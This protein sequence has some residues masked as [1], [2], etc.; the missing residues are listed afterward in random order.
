MI[1]GIGGCSYE[2]HAPTSM[3]LHRRKVHG[4]EGS[5]STA[6][7]NRTVVA[8]PPLDAHVMVFDTPEDRELIA[9]L[10]E[11]WAL[12]PAAALAELKRR[13]LDA[14]EHDR[15]VRDVRARRRVAAPKPPI[16]LVR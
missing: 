1:C 4:I 10:S 15:Y 12:S 6:K 5:S 9:D 8:R 14:I 7:R 13:L 3:G 2:H 11:A 16:H